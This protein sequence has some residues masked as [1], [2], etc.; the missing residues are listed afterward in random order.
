MEILEDKDLVILLIEQVIIRE[1]MDIIGDVLKKT[2]LEEG[3][4]MIENSM[5]LV[6]IVEIN[7]LLWKIKEKAIDWCL[8]LIVE[9][10]TI[11]IFNWY[12]F[13]LFL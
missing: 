6:R 4:A 13:V 8:L 2:L 10:I 7:N 11:F 5:E 1:E 12:F 3:K 9:L